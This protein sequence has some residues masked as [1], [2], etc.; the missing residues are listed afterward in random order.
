MV[1]Y[2]KPNTPSSALT[3]RDRKYLDRFLTRKGPF[4]D[5]DSFMAGEQVIEYLSNLKVL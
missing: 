1:S 4:T 3:S 5:E 2:R